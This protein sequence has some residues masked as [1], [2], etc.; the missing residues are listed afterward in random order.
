MSKHIP[1]G[2]VS[3]ESL[4]WAS[5]EFLTTRIPIKTMYPVLN[6]EELFSHIDK[7]R[8]EEHEMW[9]IDYVFNAIGKL[10]RSAEEHYG[11]DR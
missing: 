9:E 3:P 2:S 5:G 6:V 4:S 10:A 7:Y 1:D 8:D 11:V